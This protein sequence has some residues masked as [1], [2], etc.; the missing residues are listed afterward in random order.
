MNLPDRVQYTPG[1]YERW[2]AITTKSGE[3]LI[4]IDPALGY[5]INGRDFKNS[6]QDLFSDDYRAFAQRYHLMEQSPI[7]SGAEHTGDPKL[8]NITVVPNASASREA[9]LFGCTM[10]HWH[11]QA[12]CPGEIQEVYEF[13]SY[14]AL[15]IDRPESDEVD[16]WIAQDGDK[17]SIPQQCHMTLYNLDDLGHPLI[18]LDFA[19]P[20]RNHANKELVKQIG[21]IL[22]A[23]YTADEAVFL[24][25][26]HYIN[27]G[28]VHYNSVHATGI[29]NH[30]CLNGGVRQRALGVNR[31]VR[32]ALGTRARLGERIYEALTE[33]PAMANQ[34]NKLGIRVL[35]ASPEV[36]ITGIGYSRSLIECVKLG[37]NN[38]LYQTFLP[39]GSLNAAGSVNSTGKSI[40]AP[41]R[42]MHVEE[43]RWC[44]L[45][46]RFLEPGRKANEPSQRDIQIL[47]EGAGTWVENAFIPSIATARKELKKRGLRGLKVIIAD[48]SRWHTPGGRTPVLPNPQDY[49]NLAAAI[50]AGDVV[51]LDKADP[52][53]FE[54]YQGLTPGVVFVI[55]P[56]YTHSQLCQAHLDRA[57]TIF[58]EK[59]FDANWKNVRALLETRGRA[60]LDTQIYALDHYR[61]YSWRL[62]EPGSS[63]ATL[64]EE[65]TSHLGGALQAVKF[66]MTEEKPIA[67]SRVRTLQYGLL[68]DML[69]H[70]FGMLSFF[71]KLSSLDEFEIMN[72]GRYRG[73]P[74]S[75][76]TFAHVRFTFEDYSNNGWR[77]PCE[78]YVGK[79][80]KKGRKYFEVIGSNGKSVLIAFGNTNWRGSAQKDE[81]IEGGIYFVDTG[82]P[83]KKA[84]LTSAS[85][86]YSQ[87]FIDMV[88]GERKAIISAMPFI[89]GEQ[90]VYALDR[91]WTA[92]QARSTWRS[93]DIGKLDCLK[94]V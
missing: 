75:N 26:K 72:V 20:T 78:A 76:E 24:L 52:G 12:N 57:S 91:F 90:I 84:S 41:N 42:K 69:P 1:Q 10:G 60:N 13:Q 61:F 51:F 2:I 55:T 56:D 23:Y 14:G 49:P 66:L 15:V 94:K 53:D 71:G 21:P 31:E 58:V 19:N 28:H 89:A 37:P 79:G 34:F 92:A 93:Y 45:G 16:L 59:P 11:E 54:F 77:V 70:C 22:L 83:T 46:P 43:S 27:R 65:A 81:E 32:I 80:L 64:L 88:S 48:D 67:P 63:G 5:T 85:T 33:D 40:P 29:N 35:R 18:T 47:I 7:Y 86:R 39:S 50:R 68:L 74:I 87:L 17:V 62:K 82:Q 25:N 73:A 38:S 4:T 3:A 44:E 9:T 6:F 30:Q 36:K 8:P